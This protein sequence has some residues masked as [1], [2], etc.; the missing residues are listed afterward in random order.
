MYLCFKTPAAP[1]Y[2]GWKDRAI[3]LGN[4][5]IGAKVFGGVQR[6]MIQFN[7]KTLFSGDENRIGS[8]QNLGELFLSFNGTVPCSENT[9]LRD[10]DLETGSAMVACQK[11]L[12]GHT[13]HYFVSA[14]DN[15]LV[16]KIESTG[17][18]LLDFTLSLQSEQNGIVT[19]DGANAYIKGTVCA[20]NGV[21]SESGEDKNNLRY[22]CCVKVI[23]DDGEMLTDSDGITVRDTFGARIVMSCATD[24]FDEGDLEKCRENVENAADMTFPQLFRRHL[25][26]YKSIMGRAKLNICQ[27]DDNL[28]TD[29]Q[30]KIYSKGR[31]RQNLEALLFEMGKY[32]LYSSSRTESLPITECGIW[33]SLNVQ[34]QGEILINTKKAAEAYSTAKALCMDEVCTSFDI[35]KEKSG[36]EMRYN[37]FSAKKECTLKTPSRSSALSKLF[38]RDKTA[39]SARDILDDIRKLSLQQGKETQA[40]KAL[41]QVVLC[42][43]DN[44]F[45][46]DI[47]DNI[48]YTDT[49]SRLLIDERDGVITFLPSLPPQWEIGSFS[50]F[51]IGNFEVGFEWSGGKFSKGTVKAKADGECRLFAKGKFIGVADEDGNDI[52]ETFE[53]GI[54]TFS[55]HKSK[56]YNLY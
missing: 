5:S 49:V 20:N 39:D 56:T 38:K 40:Y 14:K 17:D 25:D 9:Y 3:P 37:P 48:K 55:V 31:D 21:G 4:G 32:I 10:L 51:T 30:L 54:I 42:S 52:E 18:T 50:A 41:S 47:F 28:T 8:F 11:G 7:E 29:A 23:P 46:P 2:T 13:R 44:L 35:F 26:D 19:Y 1:N 24:Y 12:D 53:N 43:R 16:G 34:P 22:I 15:V 45:M 33:N 36:E 27:S 6:E